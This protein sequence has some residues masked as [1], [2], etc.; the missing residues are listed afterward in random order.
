MQPL[1]NNGADVTFGGKIWKVLATVDQLKKQ[2]RTREAKRLLDVVR[3]MQHE[4]R[5]PPKIVE[6][7]KGRWMYRLWAADDSLLYIGITDRGREREREHARTKSWWPEVHHVT[8]EHIATRA[9]LRFR[10]AE[11]IRKERPRYNVQHN[12]GR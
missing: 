6:R 10:E 1:S 12:T 9:E 8:V 2:G 5:F 4:A 3:K 11:A 7:I